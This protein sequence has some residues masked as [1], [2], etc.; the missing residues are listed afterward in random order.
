M[1]YTYLEHDIYLNMCQQLKKASGD[2]KQKLKNTILYNGDNHFETIVSIVFS[3]ISDGVNIVVNSLN[4]LGWD[5][6][7]KEFVLDN[8]ECFSIIISV[9]EN[10]ENNYHEIIQE[11]AGMETYRNIRKATRGCFLGGGQGIDGMIT[12]AL[13]ASGA[14]IV[15]G[16]GHSIVNFIGNVGTRLKVEKKTKDLSRNVCELILKEELIECTLKNLELVFLQKTS[17]PGC[18]VFLQEY[19]TNHTKY[20]VRPE[21]LKID[22]AEKK[23]K[24]Y[25]SI[26]ESIP[27]CP[28]IYKI[29]LMEYG[30]PKKELQLLAMDYDVEIN[31]IKKDLLWEEVSNLSKD[32]GNFVNQLSEIEKKYSYFDNQLEQEI[33]KKYLD[34][35][36]QNNEINYLSKKEIS[37]RVHFLK[38][39]SKKYQY[40]IDTYLN[41]IRK[42]I[43]EVNHIDVSCENSLEDLEALKEKIDFLS[44]EYEMDFQ[45]YLIIV[46]EKINKISLKIAKEES[47]KRTVYDI[48]EISMQLGIVKKRKV[49][50]NSIAEAQKIQ[51][52]IDEMCALFDAMNF[53]MCDGKLLAQLVKMNGLMENF[54][55][56]KKMV[57]FIKTKQAEVNLKISKSDAQINNNSALRNDAEEKKCSGCGVIIKEGYNFCPKCGKKL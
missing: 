54:P 6:T 20:D 26:L 25:F 56:C 29:L 55:Y 23:R 52:R 21:L 36:I 31:I 11:I 32:N 42:R 18:G 33:Y 5:V 10:Y 44:L 57:E 16:A 38:D 34:D 19:D 51:K 13:T 4:R 1:K 49:T 46:Q 9:L 8:A 47:E 41:D 53:E 7:E 14:N 22:D 45:E 40:N 12:G 3:A 39:F 24:T 48:S 35:F 17:N 2:G 27:Y 50:L 30:D 43:A 15:A 37:E 28:V